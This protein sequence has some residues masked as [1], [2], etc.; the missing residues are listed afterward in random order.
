LDPGTAD[1]LRVLLPRIAQDYFWRVS[2]T[3]GRYTTVGIPRAAIFT[4]AVM[5]PVSPPVRAMREEPPPE[6]VSVTAFNPSTRLSYTLARAGQVRITVFNI[7]GQEILRVFDG[8]QPAGA[9][10][11]DLAKLQLPNGMYFYR[12]QAPGIFE[13]KKVIVS[14]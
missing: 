10:Q 13:T 4:I 6:T 7:L 3:D 11:V 9:Y 5:T 1:S 12:L 8:T 2:A 14:R